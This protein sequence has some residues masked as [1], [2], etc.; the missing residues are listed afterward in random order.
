MTT[1]IRW[2]TPNLVV[3]GGYDPNCKVDCCSTAVLCEQGWV[4][5]DPV[6]LPEAVLAELLRTAV[7]C[8][9]LLTSGNHERDSGFWKKTFGIPVFAPEGAKGEVA[10]DHWI[11]QGDELPGSARCIGLSGG[12][13]GESAYLIEDTLILGDA[14]IN[15]SGLEILPSK[16]CRDFAQLQ[17]SLQDLRSISPDTICFAH[18][19]PII[20][21]AATALHEFLDGI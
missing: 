14:I 16:Y 4:V 6:P 12:A 8:A 18:G 11:R 20:T 1:E 17:T 15:L 3:W 2:V 7:P 19:W 21:D 5:I 13:E 10:A 9:I